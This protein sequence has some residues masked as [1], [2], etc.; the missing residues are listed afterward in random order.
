MMLMTFILGEEDQL[1][2]IKVDYLLS[3]DQYA[4]LEK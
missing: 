3:N 1:M 4:Q 2:K